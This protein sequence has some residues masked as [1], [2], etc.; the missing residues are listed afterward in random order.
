MP[1]QSSIRRRALLIGGTSLVTSLA[2]CSALADSFTNSEVDGPPPLYE[3]VAENRREEQC[4]VDLLVERNGEIVYWEI[5]NVPVAD[6]DNDDKHYRQFQLDSPEWPACGTH[7]VRAR[8]E[9]TWATL[10]FADLQP[11]TGDMNNP[12]ELK[13]IITPDD[14][15][16]EAWNIQNIDYDCEKRDEQ[17]A[18]KKN[19]N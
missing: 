7:V 18:S 4:S 14:L 13:I 6:P 10:D 3:I 15:S 8:I 2:G 5:N 9:S 16:M 19:E 17:N 12:V 11:E 1:T